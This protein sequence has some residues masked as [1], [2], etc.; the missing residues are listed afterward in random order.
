MDFHFFE[1]KNVPMRKV[2]VLDLI[3]LLLLLVLLF[4]YLQTLN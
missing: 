2:I 1:K 4:T 3:I